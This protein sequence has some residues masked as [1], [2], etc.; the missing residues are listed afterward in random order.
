MLVVVGLF[1]RRTIPESP[2]FQAVQRAGAQATVPAA[3][4][5]RGCW[6]QILLAMGA[7]CAQAGCVYVVTTFVLTYAT[8]SVGLPRQ[9]VL[10]A[11]VLGGAVQ[12]VGVPLFGALSDQLGHRRVFLF[13]GAFAALMAVPFFRLIDAR[14]P[15]LLVLALIA[16]TLGPAAMYGPL[17]SLFAALFRAN[18]RYSGLSLGYQLGTVLAGGLSPLLATLLLAA[19]GGNPTPIGVYMIG[20]CLVSVACVLAT[21]EQRRG[22]MERSHT[23]ETVRQVS[24]S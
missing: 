12:L 15:G 9:T 7:S 10:L 20:L 4:A 5:L 2:E 1:V 24:W 13:G 23:A 6:Q 11:V 8:E 16:G 22:P 19:S 21:S 17:G 3:E 14:E 18:V